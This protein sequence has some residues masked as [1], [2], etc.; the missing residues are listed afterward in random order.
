[1]ALDEAPPFWWKKPGWQAVLLSPLAFFYGRVSA[2]RMAA[3]PSGSVPVPVICVG[4]FVTGG[5]GKTPTVQMLVRYARKLGLQ[6]GILSRGHGGAIT[7]ATIV[8]PDRHN[9]HD[10]GDEALLHAAFAKTVISP[11]RLVGAELL[12]EEG[13]DLIIMDDGFQ[14]PHLQKDYCLVVVDARRGLGNGF[15][16]PAGPMRVPVSA[17]MHHVDGL[18]VIG[19]G[20]GAARVIRKAARAAKPIFRAS[21]SVVGKT[22]I[23]GKRAIAFAGIGDPDKFFDM[24]RKI[25]VDLVAALPFGDHHVYLEEEC[26]DLLQRAEKDGEL[27]LTTTKDHARL[28]GMGTLQNKLA[29]TCETVKIELVPNDPAIL[30]R[31]VD[32]A[33]ERARK[34]KLAH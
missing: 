21:V 11:D 2:R 1:M 5:A 16:M 14:N 32:T 24:L 30:S 12:A 23:A 29:E 4:N 20:D 26:E 33:V 34:R 3:A 22:R 8:K 10:V 9:A 17:Q 19:D 31:I 27:L 15:T 13:C 28:K 25:G 7:S 18:I 6:P